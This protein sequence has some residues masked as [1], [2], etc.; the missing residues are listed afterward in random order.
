MRT[1]VL[2]LSLAAFSCSPSPPPAPPPPVTHTTIGAPLAYLVEDAANVGRHDWPLPRGYVALANGAEG[3]TTARQTWDFA[4]FGSYEPE[5][6]DGFQVAEVGSDRYIRFTSTRDGGTPWEQHFVGQR[7]GGSGW[8]VFG[9]DAPTGTWREVVATLNIARDPATCP[10]S[11]NPAYT[12]Y[13]LEQ[14]E[15]P[16]AVAGARST[17]IISTVISEHYDH[18]TIAE[19]GALERSYLGKGYGLLRWE[20]WGRSPPSITDLP[21]RCG[22]VAYSEPPQAGWHLRDCRQ[23]SVIP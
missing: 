9:Q 23:Y 8:I 22:P 15:Y 5:R 12:R 13:R 18:K 6:G 2:A 3:N 4:P 1:I 19:A 21:E 11:L 10:A 7:C 16:F 17:R 14:V 20:A